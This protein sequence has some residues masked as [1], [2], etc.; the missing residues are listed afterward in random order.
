MKSIKEEVLEEIN[1]WV[2]DGLK[3]GDYP[4]INDYSEKAISLTLQKVQKI[5]DEWSITYENCVGDNDSKDMCKLFLQDI[6]E[7]NQKLKERK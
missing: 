5:I 7:L 1:K 4:K 6:K 2:E 3:K